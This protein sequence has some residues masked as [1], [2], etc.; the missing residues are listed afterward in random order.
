MGAYDG[1]D[2][3]NLPFLPDIYGN[4]FPVFEFRANEIEEG[5]EP[6][7]AELALA[8]L[9]REE[10]VEPA[11]REGDHGSGSGRVDSRVGLVE[12]VWSVEVIVFKGIE[13]GGGV[14]ETG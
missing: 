4:A 11:E 12:I 13:L 8:E 5:V 14:G 3:E 1:I 10:S 6:V 2:Y 7:E 9:D